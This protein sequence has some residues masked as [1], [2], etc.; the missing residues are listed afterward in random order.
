[1]LAIPSSLRTQ[2]QQRLDE[3]TIPNHLAGVYLT[4]LRYYLDFCHKYHFPPDQQGESAALS[5]ETSR[6]NAKHRH[7]RRRR[8]NPMSV[9]RIAGFRGDW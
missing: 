9:L 5:A 2:F 7:N 8:R 1:M 4:W 6:R 3:K